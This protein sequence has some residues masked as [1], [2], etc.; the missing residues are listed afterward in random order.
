MHLSDLCSRRCDTIFGMN[1]RALGIGL[2][3]TLSILVAFPVLA[4]A[5]TNA[6]A[7][8]NA[9]CA[10]KCQADATQAQAAKNPSLNCVGLGGAKI[11]TCNY[12]APGANVP[13]QC[14]VGMVCQAISASGLNGG[15]A[16]S[17]LSQLSGLLGQVLGKLMQGS[18]GSGSGSGS[19]V[20]AT[21]G[22]TTAYFYTSDATQIGV[23]P[24]ALFQPAS[25]C[26]DPTATNFGASATCTYSPATTCSDPTAT[27][28]GASVAC[29]YGSGASGTLSATPQT[30][31][32]PLSVTF[33]TGS[34]AMETYSIDFGDGSTYGAPSSIGCTSTSPSTCEYQTTHTYASAGTYTVTLYDQNNTAAATVSVSVTNP[35]GSTGGLSQ[36]LGSVSNFL[37]GSS[38]PQGTTQTSPSFPGIFGNLLLDQNGATIFASTINSANNSETSG[39]Y[40]SDTLGSSQSFAGHLCQSR[41]WASNFLANIIPPLFF[42][43]L[44]QW[45]GYQV[46]Q[47]VQPQVTLVQ[48]PA[49]ARQ[50]AAPVATTTAATS[51]AATPAQVQIWAVPSAVPLGARTSIFWNTQNATSCTESSPDGNFSQ[52]SLAGAASTVPLTGATTYTISC[53]D[54]GGNPVTDYVTV[55]ISS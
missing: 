43:S 19:T 53:L 29:T 22:C 51:T 41:P 18:S 42:D 15:N 52:N 21:T 1:A 35:G 17:S 31:A 14:L 48:Q 45:G 23:N 2:Y 5:Q 3:I 20:P 44:C 36:V 8:Q 30:G 25:T 32:A 49:A 37:T 12:S 27:N 10:A 50:Q 34:I 26:S 11:E 33:T 4:N 16:M 38:S 39:F 13:G 7:A 24:C 54:Q 40:G 28:F 6:A 9:E 47:P 46:G 55:K